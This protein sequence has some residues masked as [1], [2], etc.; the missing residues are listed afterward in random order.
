MSLLF[1]GD[2][3][4]PKQPLWLSALGP[5]VPPNNLQVSTLTV[6]PTGGIAMTSDGQAYPNTVG[7]PIAFNRADNLG[8]SAAELRMEPSKNVPTKGVETT[9]LASVTNGGTVYDDIALQ[10]LQIYGPQVT[11]PAANQGCAGYLTRGP[12]PFSTELYTGNFITP[13]VT[14]SIMNASTINVSSFVVPGT[15]TT[16]TLAVSSIVANGA[17]IS[18]LRAQNSYFTLANCSSFNATNIVTSTLLTSTSIFPGNANLNSIVASTITANVGTFSTLNAPGGTY[19]S[20]VNTQSVSTAVAITKELFLSSMV[21]NAS[22]SPNFNIEMGGIVGGL[23][24]YV[25]ANTLGVA[26]GAANLATGI[27]SL[28]MSRQSGGI[29]PAVYQTVNGTSQ[30]QFSTLGQATQTTFVTTDAIDYTHNSG[31]PVYTS[32]IIPANTYCMRTVSDPLNLANSDGTA[33]KGIQGYSQWEPVYPGPTQYGTSSITLR[34]SPNYIEIDQAGLGQ[35]NLQIWA[36][37][38]VGIRGG[39]GV[40]IDTGFTG[41][42]TMTGNAEIYGNLSIGQLSTLSTIQGPS[43]IRIVPGLTTPSIVASTIAVSSLIYNTAIQPAINTSSITTGTLSVTNNAAISQTVRLATNG[44]QIGSQG[45]FIGQTVLNPPLDGNSLSVQKDIQAD[46]LNIRSIISNQGQLFVLGDTS[47]KSVTASTLTVGLVSTPSVVANTITT[48]LITATNLNGLGM[49]PYPPTNGTAGQQWG[50]FVI[51]GFRIT[52][53]I[54]NGNG[55]R[56]YYSTAGFTPNFGQPPLVFLTSLTYYNVPSWWSV[57]DRQ[58]N[59]MTC[60]G[61]NEPGLPFNTQC[62]WVAIGPA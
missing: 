14:T 36:G 61:L 11:A 43:P 57:V 28:A 60:F 58:V 51:A 18:T 38:Y 49:T 42:T 15:L 31:N 53:G 22:L 59:G 54:V 5:N 33:G 25:G 46:S 62:Q 37:N 20:S 55:S 19:T 26:L 23:L 24:G 9:Y 39:A 47:L 1:N 32:T 27:A 17:D 44:G 4:N 21:F 7:A 34:G 56:P 45:V 41:L 48:P 30:V 2:F 3:A 13:Q 52:W 8:S 29:N 16:S 35:N 40:S 6:N 50:T 10:G 12:D